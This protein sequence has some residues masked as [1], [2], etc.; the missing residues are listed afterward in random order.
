MNRT[1]RAL[2]GFG[3][4]NWQENVVA[5]LCNLFGKAIFREVLRAFKFFFTLLLFAWQGKYIYHGALS[6][7]T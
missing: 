3:M 7:K 6:C 4:A 1:M 2:L 5:F